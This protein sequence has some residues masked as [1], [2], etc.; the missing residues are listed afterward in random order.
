ML[1]FIIRQFNSVFFCRFKVSGKLTHNKTLIRPADEEFISPES[2]EGQAY[3]SAYKEARK[4]F[5]D[6]LR[7]V[8]T[9]GNT[10][11]QYMSR[12][13]QSDVKHGLNV[14]YVCRDLAAR[15]VNKAK[16]MVSR[17]MNYCTLGDNV[18]IFIQKH[19]YTSLLLVCNRSFPF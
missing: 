7:Y 18:I 3:V 14:W 6:N 19:L 2:I 17:T 12:N 16:S 8:T 15:L 13:K 11:I 9:D 5:K 1:V 10:H 4:T